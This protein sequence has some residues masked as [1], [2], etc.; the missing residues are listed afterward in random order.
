MTS[1]LRLIVSCSRH[2]YVAKAS[3][4]RAEASFTS[5]KRCCNSGFWAVAGR[6]V[7]DNPTR[8]VITATIADADLRKLIVIISSPVSV[9]FGPAGAIAT[10]TMESMY[11][12]LVAYRRKTTATNARMP[13][14]DI[15]AASTR[16]MDRGTW[17]GYSAFRVFRSRRCCNAAI[18]S[19][20][21]PMTIISTENSVALMTRSCLP[22]TPSI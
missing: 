20:T 8:I 11:Q 14:T 18:S 17:T 19:E 1:P 12:N 13:R 2:V 10:R 16:A 9:H 5:A 15:S 3:L 6:P 4:F 22:P 21:N 7:S